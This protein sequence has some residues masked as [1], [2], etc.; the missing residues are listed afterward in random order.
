MTNIRFFF[1]S[2]I[3]ASLLGASGVGAQTPNN[4]PVGTPIAASQQAGDDRW[5]FGGEYEVK[6]DYRRNFALDK[7]ARDDLFRFDQELQLRGTFQV[8]DWVSLFLEGKVLGDHQLYTGGGA[9]RSDKSLERGETWLRFENLLGENL[10]FKIGRQNFDEPRQWWWDDDLDALALRF[11]REGFSLEFG[12]ARQLAQVDFLRSRIEPEEDGVLRLL[13]RANWRYSRGHALDLFSLHQQDFSSTPR[14]G[15]SVRAGR[16]DESD[17][18]LWWGGVRASGKE[19]LDGIGEWSYWVDL[20]LVAGREKLLEFADAPGRRKVVT[21][22]RRQSVYG[23]AVDAGVRLATEL[24]GRPIVTLSYAVGSGD[25]EPQR[26]SD[27]SFRQTGLQSNDDEFRTYGELLRP[28]LAN[29]RIPSVA[30]ALPL[31]AGSHIE[32]A[33]RNFR[34]VHAAPFLRNAR[35][36][37]APNGIDKNIGNE[38]MLSAVIKEWRKFE[39][40]IIGAAFKAGQAFRPAAGK[41]AYSF[42]AKLSYSF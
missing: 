33:F 3:L 6:L 37:A 24:P 32:L 29:L 36:E 40:E 39:V 30:V 9:R 18:K 26:G 10:S 2:M 5:E 15:A 38:W 22:R 23:R 11:R 25:R 35:I 17:A 8:N 19:P 28:E 27:R 16:E 21:S 31:F 13:T 41:N 20:A 34:Q 7:P 14:A 4:L 12:V 1:S 42:F